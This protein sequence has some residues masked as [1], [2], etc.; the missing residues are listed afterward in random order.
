MESIY[1]PVTREWHQKEAS[2]EKNAKH[3]RGSQHQRKLKRTQSQGLSHAIGAVAGRS[4]TQQP[5]Y[6]IFEF[7][8]T[9][10]PLRRHRLI[11][12]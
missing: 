9:T 11:G 8:G 6:K 5:L 2:R 10:P 7:N 1:T 3:T 12:R 4:S